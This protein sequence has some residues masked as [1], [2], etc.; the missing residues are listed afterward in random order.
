MELKPISIKVVLDRLR[1]HPMLSDVALESMIDYAVDFIRIMGLPAAFDDKTAILEVDKYMA[2]L[3]DDFY[4][5]NQVR[6]A[7]PHPVY[8]RYTTDTFYKSD[9][10]ANAAHFTY[11]I[12][13]EVIH[14]SIEKGFIEIAYQAIAVDECGLPMIPDNAK[15]I[16]ALENYV[17]LQKF[18]ILFDEGKISPNV[19]QRADQEYCWAV[20]AC[21]T[22]LKLLTIDKVESIANIM[23]TLVGKD[24]EHYR[25]Y[26][27]SG[28]KEYI[29]IH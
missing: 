12:Q 11:K 15:F 6:T 1:R 19:I 13:G 24:N 14:T 18:T 28:D 8:F 20:G 23:K 5:M 29:K 9:N 4:V 25:G 2:K 21:D 17:K 16:R 26:A 27:H 3:P 7:E 10:K 22:E